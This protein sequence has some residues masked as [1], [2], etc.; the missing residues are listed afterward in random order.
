MYQNL[1][2]TAKEVIIGKFYTTEALYQKRQR[3]KKR[4]VAQLCQTL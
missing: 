1:W 2:D 3:K 4:E